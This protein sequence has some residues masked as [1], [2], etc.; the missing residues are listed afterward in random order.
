[1]EDKKDLTKKWEEVL[2]SDGPKLD[3]YKKWTLAQIFENCKNENA[4]A[5]PQLLTEASP[6]PVNSTAGIQNFD[7]IL[8]SMMRRRLPNLLP[9]EVA[10]VQPMTG[11]PSL[12]LVLRKIPQVSKAIRHPTFQPIQ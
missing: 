12:I 6:G 11:P 8:I 9:F 7:P 3:K 4:F 2:E 5:I 1:M 10:G